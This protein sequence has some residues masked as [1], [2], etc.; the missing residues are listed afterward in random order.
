MKGAILEILN[1]ELRNCPILIYL[2]KQDLMESLNED[3]F[4]QKM[5]E[6]ELPSFIRNRS[7]HIQPC[8]GRTG[9]G[10]N[11]GLNWLLDTLS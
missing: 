1:D 5:A 4:I 11:E 9:D 7:I 8:I 10:V 3:S 2:N 6:M